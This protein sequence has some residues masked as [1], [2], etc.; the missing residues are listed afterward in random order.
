[1][2]AATTS[3]PSTPAGE[4][5]TAGEPLE[6][7]H[8]CTTRDG[9]RLAL[10]RFRP[11]REGRRH[12]VLLVPGLSSN[13]FSY[14]LT[15][16]ASLARYLA[17][18]GYDTWILE[19]RGH[20]RSDRPKLVG[21]GEAWTFDDHLLLDFPAALARIRELTSRPSV[22]VIG[23]SMGGIMLY[24]HM[25]FGGEGVR[26]AVTIGSSLDYSRSSSW[27]HG[28]MRFL[29]LERWVPAVPF[30][31][32]MQLTSPLRGHRANVL[33][34]LNAWHANV[35]PDEYRQLCRLNFHVISPPV[36]KQLASAFSDGGLRSVDGSW[37]YSKGL[38]GEPNAPLLAL[39]GSKDRQCPPEAVAHTLESVRGAE[40]R[41][42]GRGQGHAEHYGH[43]DLVMGKHAPQEL[44]PLLL[45]WL[46][47]NDG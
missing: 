4:P 17:R 26:S 3:S 15:P 21:K 20:G 8:T 47:R 24:G 22:H 45:A 37:R 36:L 33:D 44:W 40:L 42:F 5:L 2:S 12:P 9:W 31:P 23:H 10:T 14:D 13:R 43:F 30:G 34:E 11:V 38:Q 1:M 7:V 35:V 41:V 19:L 28:L 32:M 29:W 25:G 46:D 6:E 39:G 16:R 27:F 18:H